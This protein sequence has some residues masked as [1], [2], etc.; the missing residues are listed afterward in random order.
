MHLYEM[1]KS[2][3]VRDL[4]LPIRAL[5]KL[6]ADSTPDPIRQE[7]LAEAQD[8]RLTL[9]EVE[10]RIAAAKAETTEA[11]RQLSA[12]QF[13]EERRQL[14][15]QDNRMTNSRPRR[16]P[17]TPNRPTTANLSLCP[18]GS[19]R[20]RLIVWGIFLNREPLRRV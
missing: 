1:D 17:A 18:A 11:Q 8:N 3:T 9:A 19:R 5:Y 6:A 10:A 2:R 15:A 13:E 16:S 7:I 20:G 4:N 14:T 12:K